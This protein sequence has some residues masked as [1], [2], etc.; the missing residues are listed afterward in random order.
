MGAVFHPSTSLRS[1][2][3]HLKLWHHKENDSHRKSQK[4]GLE[5]CQPASSHWFS[6]TFSLS[7]LV[8]SY[9]AITV[10]LKAMAPL[11]NSDSVWQ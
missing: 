10:L 6:A 2:T 1:H 3:C 11:S 5:I 8:L 9:F 4:N 7:P